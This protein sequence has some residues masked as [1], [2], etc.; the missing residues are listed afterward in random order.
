MVVVICFHFKLDEDK[1]EGVS[2]VKA[3]GFK[4]PP[5]PGYKPKPQSTASEASS[6]PTKKVRGKKIIY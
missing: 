4:V 5:P 6:M 2:E 1:T 3:K